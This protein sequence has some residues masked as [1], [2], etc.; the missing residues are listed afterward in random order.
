MSKIVYIGLGGFLGAS[1]RYLISKWVE[2]KWE[3]VFPSGTLVVNTLGSF[4]LGF[5]MV[6][7]IE[8]TANYTNLKIILT[9]G[10]LGAFTTFSTFS[11]ETMMLLEDQSFLIAGLNIIANFF[12]GLLAVM[13][14]IFIARTL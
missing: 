4:L 12:L 2:M 6:I 7:F 8:K 11:F 1:S 3:N 5:L 10:F 13:L 14:G 9:T